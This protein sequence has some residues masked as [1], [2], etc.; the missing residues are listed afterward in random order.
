MIIEGMVDDTIITDGMGPGVETTTHILNLISAL[1]SQLDL[2][3]KL[4]NQLDIDSG[5][6]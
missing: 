4:V 6:L 1:I 2:E 3:S 5:L